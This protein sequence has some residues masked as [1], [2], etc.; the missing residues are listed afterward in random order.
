MDEKINEFL[1]K[2]EKFKILLFILITVYE[3]F[4]SKKIKLNKSVQTKGVKR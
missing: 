2:N 1:N 4:L 3:M